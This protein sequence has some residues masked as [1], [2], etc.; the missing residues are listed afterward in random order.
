MISE[1]L[2]SAINRDD[3]TQMRDGIRDD[4]VSEY[5]DAMRGGA[6]F[7]PVVVFTE[8]GNRYHLADGFHR[9]E[10]AQA[11]NASTIQADV[12]SGGHRDA[13]LYAAGANATH[14]LR[15]TNADKRKSVMALLEDDEWS[16]MSDREIARHCG[17]THPFVGKLRSS[18]EAVSSGNSYHHPP[19]MAFTS[20]GEIAES[21]QRTH[22][23]IQRAKSDIRQMVDLLDDVQS[24]L[25]PEQYRAWRQSEL[26]MTGDQEIAIRW[27]NASDSAETML[28]VLEGIVQR[29]QISFIG[30]PGDDGMTQKSIAEALRARYGND[31]AQL[32]AEAIVTEAATS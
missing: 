29:N 24:R 17:V 28:A 30:Y 7:P 21:S 18:L 26:G 1:I 5:A 9:V 31:G 16:A 10:A 20:L 23:L 8:D 27:A 3:H 19:A 11:V 22:M 13:R 2:L 6:T 4:V 25:A 14:G 12:R 15:R 32:I